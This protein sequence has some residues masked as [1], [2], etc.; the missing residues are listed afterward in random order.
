MEDEL[1]PTL[2]RLVI[3]EHNRRG[4]QKSVQ[5]N[6]AVILLVAMWAVLHDRPICWACGGRDGGGP[7]PW[8]SLPGGCPWTS[9]PSRGTMSRRLQ[10]L[11][12]KQLLEQVFWRLLWLTP[13][14]TPPPPPPPP[15]MLRK[16]DSKPLPVGGFSK[17]R[18]AKR[19]HCCAGNLARGYKLF[20][21]WGNGVGVVPEQLLLGPM[22]LSDPAGAMT[23]IDGLSRG[24]TPGGY[25]LAD[26]THDTNPLHAYAREHDFQL[27]APR[28][29]PGTDL[30]HCRHDPGRLRGI[31]M[32]EGPSSFGRSLY[33]T[34]GDIERD[35]GHMGSFGGGLQPLPSFVRRP[36][37]VA[38]WIILK[39]IINGIRIC[40]LRGLTP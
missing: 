17:D 26:S 28:K 2:Y 15:P 38:S 29:Q 18:D 32:L 19:G 34:R 1:W 30:G 40:R 37:R 9:L 11:S 10:T 20:G 12:L 25:L 8:R 3:E 7:D 6:D 14:A 13:T 35:F 31:Q 24:P 36:R 33:A 4:R 22:N 39:L 21:C 23:L 27:L 5:F 16:L